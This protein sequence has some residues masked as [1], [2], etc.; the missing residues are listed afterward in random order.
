MKKTTQFNQNKEITPEAVDTVRLQELIGAGRA[1]AV[2][3][4]TEAGARIQIGRRVLWNVPKIRK[5]LEK[6]SE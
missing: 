5:Y 3:I 2:K 1:T 4:G 6:I